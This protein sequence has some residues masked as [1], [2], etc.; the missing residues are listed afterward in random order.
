M[1]GM[2]SRNDP[3]KYIQR[4]FSVMFMT[5][6]FWMGVLSGYGAADIFVL[7]AKSQIQQKNS[8]RMAAESHL[9]TK[10]ADTEQD[11]KLFSER[12]K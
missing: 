4:A 3:T 1:T 6:A 2:R 5:F 11:Q 9:K 7:S 8:P 10:A 12:N